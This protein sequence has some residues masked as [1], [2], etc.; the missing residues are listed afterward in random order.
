[1]ARPDRSRGNNPIVSFSSVGP[2]ASDLLRGQTADDAFA[3]LHALAQL[4]GCVVLMG[5]DLRSMTLIHLAEREAGRTMFRRWALNR[6]GEVVT[7]EV[8]GCSDGFEK[9]EPVLAAVRQ[10]VIVGPSRWQAFP[11]DQTL[12]LATQAIRDDPNITV[13]GDPQCRRCKDALLGGPLLD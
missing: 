9:L 2:L 4:G 10:D 5:V 11:A 7:V 1:M 8:G 6:E 13:C 12:G 3:P